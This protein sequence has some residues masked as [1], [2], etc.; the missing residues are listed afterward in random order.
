MRPGRAPTGLRPLLTM[1]VVAQQSCT[2]LD[3]KVDIVDR[4]TEIRE[5][6]VESQP[7]RG[8]ERY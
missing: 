3:S 5:R 7:E 6:L 4:V 8:K 2:L 1:T